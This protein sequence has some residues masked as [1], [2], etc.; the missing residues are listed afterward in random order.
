MERLL[1]SPGKAATFT[2]DFLGQW[3]DLRLIDFTTPDKRLYPEFDE[4]LKTSMVRETQLF[5]EEVLKHDLPVQ[6]FI[7][8][9]FAMLNGRLAEHYGIP[10]VTG[11]EFRQ[12][13]LPAGSH[14]GGLLGQ[15]AILKVTANG[16]TTSPVLRGKWVLD[17]IMG[18]PPPPPPKNVGAIEP[19]IRGAK[20]IREQ[21]DMHRH[22]E[23]CA[24][25][26]TKIDPPGFALENYDVIGG[27]RDRYRVLPTRGQ[28]G[29]LRERERR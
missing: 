10:G 6:T 16:T 18:V 26:H 8:S 3:L 19:D 23:A 5:F 28:K 24:T 15:A 21:L 1:D 11:Q 20:T 25:C 14:R 2:E 9:D 13:P 17:R 22:V 27:W 29:G 4:L 12:V 7:Q